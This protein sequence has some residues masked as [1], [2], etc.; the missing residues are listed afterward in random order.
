M[1]TVLAKY[2]KYIPQILLIVLFLFGQAMGELLLPSYMSDIVNKG[3]VKNDQSYI[4]HMGMIM[5]LIS[6]GAVVFA[7]M[8]SMFAS[9]VAANASRDIRGSIFRRVMSYSAN[10]F[11]QFSTASLITRS[12][13]DVQNLQQTTIMVL[14]MAIFAPIMGVGALVNAIALSPGLTW[15]IGLALVVILLLMVGL[16]FAV[17]PKF[18]ILQDKLDRLNLIISERLSGLLV[19]RAFSS[20]Q[21]EEDRFDDANME[22]TR[23]NIFINRAMAFLF[24]SITLIMNASCVLIIW[25]GAKM[26]AGKGMMVGEVMAFMQYSIHVIMSFL[27][28][29]VMFIMIPRAAVSARRIGVVLDTQ[30]SI[31]DPAAAHA[32]TCAS[33][34]AA[35]C[36]PDAEK[37]VPGKKEGRICFDHVDF[38]YPNSG[39][40][41]LTDISFTANPGEMTAIIGGTGSGKSSLVNLLPRF[42]DV[43]GGSLTIDGV[44]IRDM[45]LKDLRSMIGFVPQKNTLFNGTVKENL[46]FGNPH[47]TDEDLKAAAKIAQADTFIEEFPDKY[48]SFIAQG[49]TSVSGGQRQRLAIARAL[50]KKAKI[51]IFDDSFSALDFSTD[52]ALRQAL[53]ESTSDST[54]LIVAQRINTIAG[55]DRIVVLDEGRVAGIGTHR[56]LLHNCDIYREIAA[57]QL[58]EEELARDLAGA[59]VAEDEAGATDSPSNGKEV[60]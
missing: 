42:Y 12:T 9:R 37:P 18:K 15:T 22:L 52:A 33:D 23:L 30:P 20:E 14:R 50:V 3:I 17:M 53:M 41:A 5:I 4:L 47:A 59:T 21:H 1:K 29:T 19:V 39:S 28:I 44:D 6:F 8:G 55:A 57:S 45:Y 38:A 46:R 7:V 26:V 56:E 58:S 10:E 27:F 43:T 32:P 13:N 25:A 51:Y 36:A 11:E 35:A 60:E 49:G 54:I 48:D 40:N 16:F 24:P 34:D 2:K 31:T